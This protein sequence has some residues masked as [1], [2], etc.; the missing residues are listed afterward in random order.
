MFLN[1]KKKLYYCP[2]HVSVVY[3]KTN[4]F[5]MQEPDVQISL[6]FQGTNVTH[7]YIFET[8]AS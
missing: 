4:I 8:V 7:G 5:P 3:T 1:D 2:L 6:F